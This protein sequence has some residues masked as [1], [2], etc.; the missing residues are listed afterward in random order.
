MKDPIDTLPGDAVKIL[1]V[2]KLLIRTT[3]YPCLFG[4]GWWDSREADTIDSCV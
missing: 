1:D 4:L 3:F 2:A